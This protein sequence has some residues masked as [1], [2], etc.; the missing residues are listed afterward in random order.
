MCN[1]PLSDVRYF[2]AGD[3]VNIF[4][5]VGL[6]DLAYSTILKYSNRDNSPRS[7]TLG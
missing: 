7:G 5:R 2:A 6:E 4:V 1:V 3:D